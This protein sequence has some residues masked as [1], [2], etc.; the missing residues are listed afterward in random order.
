[1]EASAVF[2]ERALSATPY[3]HW[4]NRGYT[5]TGKKWE[6]LSHVEKIED[7]RKQV[8]RL[9]AVANNITATQDNAA[10][11]ISGIK[12]TLNEIAKAVEQLEKDVRKNR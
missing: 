4:R 9:F 7:L 11:Q 8:K 12:L 3:V 5:M 6:E 10:S 1:M 2:H